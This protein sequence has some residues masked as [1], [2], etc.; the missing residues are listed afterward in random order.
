MV[1]HLIWFFF[2]YLCNEL[3]DKYLVGRFEIK[4]GKVELK[5]VSNLGSLHSTTSPAMVCCVK[6]SIPF[7]ILICVTEL[8][9][10][11]LDPRRCLM[12]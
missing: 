12:R 4:D 3:P 8:S 10:S 5:R 11:T 6:D 7:D 9:L 1:K 2:K